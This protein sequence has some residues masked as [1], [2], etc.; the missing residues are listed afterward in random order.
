LLNWH[1]LVA[2]FVGN[3]A[4]GT[5]QFF[6]CRKWA[7]QPEQKKIGLQILKFI[8]V[9]IGNLLLSAACVFM[10]TN[11]LELNYIISKSITSVI[12]GVSYNYLLQK[13]FV[14]YPE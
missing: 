11:Y 13:N 1:Y 12:L 6:L 8:L 2:N 14:F 10:L 7:F 5:A 3:C 9:F 4:G